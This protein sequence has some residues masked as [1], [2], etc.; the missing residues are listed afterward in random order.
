MEVGRKVFEMPNVELVGLR[1]LGEQAYHSIL[2]RALGYMTGEHSPGPVLAGL[3]AYPQSR[4][5][6]CNG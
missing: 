5:G 6:V 3:K 2:G 1:A 4:R